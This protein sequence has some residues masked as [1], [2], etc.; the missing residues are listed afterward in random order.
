MFCLDHSANMAGVKQQAVVDNINTVFELH[1]NASD[2]LSILYFNRKIDFALPPTVKK[3]NEL[4]I[5]DSMER[6]VAPRG[7]EVAMYDAVVVS[8][9]TLSLLHTVDDWLVLVTSS[10][11][12]VSRWTLEKTM[13]RLQFAKTGLIVIGIGDK[14]QSIALELLA[15]SSKKGVYFHA[16]ADKKSINEAFEHAIHIIEMSGCEDKIE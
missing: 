16:Q 12:T 2:S 5:L 6:L 10:D 3:G 8:L 14:V 15:G 11:D 4:R 7:S 9:Y 1:I 13:E